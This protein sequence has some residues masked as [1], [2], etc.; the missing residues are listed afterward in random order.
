MRKILLILISV[1]TVLS[2][3]ACA[4]KRTPYIGENGN[5]WIGKKDLG[6]CASGIEGSD[7]VAGEKGDAGRNF[8][9]TC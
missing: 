5:W 2:L 1:C 7:G 9:N 8:F 4:K 6:V 3:S